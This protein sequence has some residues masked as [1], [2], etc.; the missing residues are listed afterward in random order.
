MK[1]QMQNLKYITK[2]KYLAIRWNHNSYTYIVQ[3]QIYFL[4]VI[5]FMETS[6]TFHE[7]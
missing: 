7:L 6:S 4:R 3:K 5:I 1:I 2:N